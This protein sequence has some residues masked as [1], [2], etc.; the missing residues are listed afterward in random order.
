MEKFTIFHNCLKN[1]I[2]NTEYIKQIIERY[3]NI[4]I[5]NFQLAENDNFKHFD[6]N[7]SKILEWVSFSCIWNN[8]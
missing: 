2:E 6:M 3:D 5:E 8:L 1:N 4:Y 7:F